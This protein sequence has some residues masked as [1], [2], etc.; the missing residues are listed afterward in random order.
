LLAN[1]KPRKHEIQQT[2]KREFWKSR[3]QEGQSRAP[4]PLHAGARRVCLRRELRPPRAGAPARYAPPGRHS[5][6]G[7]ARSPGAL[8]QPFARGDR[9][10]GRAGGVSAPNAIRSTPQRRRGCS[11]CRCWARWPSSSGR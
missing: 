10:A 6:G 5:R 9:A 1:L 4:P 8:S 3:R 2:W 11:L 7:P